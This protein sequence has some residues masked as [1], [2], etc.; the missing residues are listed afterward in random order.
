MNE[1]TLRL[2]H[3]RFTELRE[4]RRTAS[5]RKRYSARPRPKPTTE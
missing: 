5:K 1:F 4:A 2:S 3:D